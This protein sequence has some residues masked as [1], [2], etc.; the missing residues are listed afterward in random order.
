MKKTIDHMSRLLEQNDISLPEG[1]NKYDVGN[2][3]ED[4]E[5]CHGIKAGFSH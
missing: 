5:R 3:T 1:A 2:K 4:H